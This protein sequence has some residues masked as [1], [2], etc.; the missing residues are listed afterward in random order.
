[1]ITT[2]VKFWSHHVHWLRDSKV[3]IFTFLQNYWI[4]YNFNFLAHL[5]NTRLQFFAGRLWWSCWNVP[6]CNL[7][8]KNFMKMLNVPKARCCEGIDNRGLDWRN[9]GL[10]SIDNYFG[11]YLKMN[12]CDNKVCGIENIITLMRIEKSPYWK[13]W[14]PG[15]GKKNS[16]KSKMDFQI[17]TE[18]E[19]EKHRSRELEWQN[20]NTSNMTNW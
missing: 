16:L 3:G 15:Q 2:T 10:V 20:N 13:I 4:I 1:M 14:K 12:V 7:V 19:E 9:S 11:R 18:Q 6:H 8:L 17:R 5:Y